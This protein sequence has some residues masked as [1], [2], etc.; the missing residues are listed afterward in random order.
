MVPSFASKNGSLN[1][2][3]PL[4]DF[5]LLKLNTTAHDCVDRVVYHIDYKEGRIKQPV[6]VFVP[7]FLEYVSKKNDCKCLIISDERVLCDYKE[8]L[9]VITSHINFVENS[10]CSLFVD[11]IKLDTIGEDKLLRV[12]N[13]PVD[14]FIYFSN[15]IISCR[16]VVTK[17][18]K[19]IFETYLQECFCETYKNDSEIIE[20]K[21]WIVL[22]LERYGLFR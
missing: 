10:N 11:K 12:D 14:E 3:V 5:N 7:K 6:C 20:D 1:Y 16:L 19:L 2:F 18:D 9:E 13:L 22:L 4:K 21:K 8:I 17:E 15:V